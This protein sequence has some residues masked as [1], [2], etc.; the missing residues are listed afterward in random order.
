MAGID[1]LG[2]VD[3]DVLI[4]GERVFFINLMTQT[5]A[6]YTGSDIAR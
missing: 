5:D 4:V 6:T 1:S 3:L 2:R